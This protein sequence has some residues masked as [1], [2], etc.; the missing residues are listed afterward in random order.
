MKP[1]HGAIIA[2]LDERRKRAGVSRRKWLACADVL[3]S[4]WYRW[5]QGKTSPRRTT[6]KRLAAA[7]DER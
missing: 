3:E 4:T 2:A 5:K 6:I 7:L 1:D